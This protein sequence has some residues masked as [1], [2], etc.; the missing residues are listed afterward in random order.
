MDAL[1]LSKFEWLRTIE[2]GDG[3]FESVKTFKM[4]GLN[5][6]KRLKVGKSSFT[7]VKQ[8]EWDLSWDQAYR[9]ANNSA[10]SFHLLNCESLKSIEIGE[11]SFS[12]FGGEFELKSLT[13]LQILVIGV[14]GKL[15]SNFW[16]SSFVVQGI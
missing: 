6:L 10:K 3:C 13:A 8:E 5:R 4:D 1:D 11:Y 2:I 12:D 15:S 14:P 9:Q 7:Q 16:W